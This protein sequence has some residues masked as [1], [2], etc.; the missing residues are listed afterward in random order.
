MSDLVYCSNMWE[1]VASV[2]AIFVVITLLCVIVCS[3]DRPRYVNQSSYQYPVAKDQLNAEYEP[4]DLDDEKNMKNT[5]LSLGERNIT[6]GLPHS[7]TST[8]PLQ[9][10]GL[11]KNGYY[12]ES[13]IGEFGTDMYLDKRRTRNNN[14]VDV[15]TNATDSMYSQVTE[16]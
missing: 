9:N 8:R 6:A 4:I 1:I 11:A 10:E 15:F 13:E 16:L 5:V 14:F 2:F 3:K 12:D 7:Q